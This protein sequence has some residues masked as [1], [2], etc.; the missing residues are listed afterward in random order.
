MSQKLTRKLVD[1]KTMPEVTALQ[2]ALQER[3]IKSLYHMHTDN[4]ENALFRVFVYI[5]D[6]CCATA[7][8]QAL[9]YRQHPE[10]TPA[11]LFAAGQKIL[12]EHQG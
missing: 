8:K 3:R 10:D 2:K 11:S 6:L 9:H 5:Q 12:K 7:I 1:L 4:E